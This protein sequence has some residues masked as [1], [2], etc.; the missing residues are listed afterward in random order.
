M[1]PLANVWIRAAI[2][3]DYFRRANRAGFDLAS[4]GKVPRNSFWISTGGVYGQLNAVEA[5]GVTMQTPLGKPELEIR[6]VR[7]SKEDPGS[8]VLDKKPVVDEFGQWIPADWPGKVRDLEQLKREWAAE[9]VGLRAGD[10][11]CC[12]YGGYLNT[13]AKATGFFR[14]EQVEGRWWFVDPDGH[15]FFLD[16]FDGHRQRQRG[17]PTCRGGRT[18]SRHCRLW[19]DQLSRSPP[20]D[21]LLCMEPGAAAWRGDGAKWVDLALRRMESW[22]MNT[23][24]NWSDPRL[25]DAQKKAY[26]VNLGGWGMETATWACPMCI[27]PSSRRSLNGPRPQCAPRK[28]TRGCWDISS[29]MSRRG[30]AANRWSWM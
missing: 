3:L 29:P 11:G 4:V 13:K 1:H 2:P 8:D 30:R 5:I 17:C 28:T 15:L 26:V 18:T 19:T 10:F 16:E 20:A 27:P 24:G 21:R 23:I 6:S 12:K 22:G 7:L 14:V 25:W 9:R